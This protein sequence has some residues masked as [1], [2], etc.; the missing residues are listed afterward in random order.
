M[1][2]KPFDASLKDMIEE[3]PRA[4]A[5]LFMPGPILDAT[6]IDADLS[7]VTAASDKVIRVRLAEGDCLM[8]LEAQS[9]YDAAKPGVMLLYSVI[10]NHRHHLPVRSIIVL[11]RSE[12]NATNL[13][14]VVELRHAPTELPYLTFHYTV[15][16]LWQ[17]PLAPIMSGP[18]G[19]LPLAP[20]TDEAAADLPGVVDQIVR[21]FRA[22]TTRAEAA[23]METM[24]FIL[25]GMRYEKAILAQLYQGVPDMEESSGY[26]L[27]MERGEQKALIRTILKLGRLKFGEPT[28]EQMSALQGIRELDRLEELTDRSVTAT[29]WE[30]LLA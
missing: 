5:E 13:T 19:L 4:W 7:T 26:Q 25:M 22:E 9:S 16:R 28:A 2:G 18:V 8:D 3:N 27:I 15:V 24:T 10:L 6:V 30:E 29:T 14:G 12:A 20:L 1:A 23:K 17:Q 21:R 11:L